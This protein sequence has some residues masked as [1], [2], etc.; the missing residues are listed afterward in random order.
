MHDRPLEPELSTAY[1]NRGA[2]FRR[3]SVGF[4]DHRLAGGSFLIIGD[5]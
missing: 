2:I 5:K 3:V 1:E 4:L